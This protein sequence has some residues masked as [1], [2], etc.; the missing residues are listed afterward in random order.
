M[1]AL[2]IALVFVSAFARA[3]DPASHFTL[4][5]NKVYSLK[6]KGVKDFVVDLTSS[7]LTRQINDQ[8][9]FGEVKKVTFR[10]YWTANP[11]RLDIEVL[12]LPEGFHEVKAQLIASILPLM[13]NVLPM[14]IQQRFPGYKFSAGTKPRTFIA[15]DASG[16]APVP[17]YVIHFDEQDKLTTVVA[18]RP[19]GTSEIKFDYEKKSF[20]D[21]KWALMQSTTTSSDSGQT[22]TSTRD[23]EYGTSQGMGIVSSV[24]LTTTQKFDKANIKPVTQSD[25]ITFE[26]YKINTGEGLKHFLSETQKNTP[27]AEP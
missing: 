5:D 24:T 23:L 3:Q 25:E 22:I 7:K 1:K 21:G 14:T 12:G 26:N 16:V 15:T 18:N 6:T 9:T 19:I 13:D 27:V 20:T 2:L 17:S 10:A 11:E 4:F 8:K